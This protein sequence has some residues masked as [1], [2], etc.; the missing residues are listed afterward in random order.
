[1]C[2]NFDW[3]SNSE[4]HHYYHKSRK[5]PFSLDGNLVTSQVTRVQHMH[6][7]NSLAAERKRNQMTELSENA[8]DWD[9][10]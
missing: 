5:D 9:K 2:M 1:M 3:H 8:W 7:N 4:F 6:V 10:P